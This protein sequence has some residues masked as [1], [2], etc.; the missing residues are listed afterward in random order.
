[1]GFVLSLVQFN[2]FTHDLNEAVEGM[3]IIFADICRYLQWVEWLITPLK[4]ELGFKIISLYR[5]AH[6]KKEESSW[7]TGRN[8]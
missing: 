8:S 4:A 3:L 7:T 6:T 5:W 2:I 1:M